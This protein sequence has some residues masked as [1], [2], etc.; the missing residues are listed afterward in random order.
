MK[1]QSSKVSDFFSV[2]QDTAGSNRFDLTPIIP[3]LV[4]SDYQSHRGPK[5]SK[6]GASFFDTALRENHNAD[7]LDFSS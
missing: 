2:L 7:R 5:L 4:W 6:T 1:I 3:C